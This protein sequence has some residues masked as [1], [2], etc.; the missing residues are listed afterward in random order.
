MYVKFTGA[1]GGHNSPPMQ[2]NCPFCGGFGTFEIVGHNLKT[3]GNT[4]FSIQSCPAIKCKAVVIGVFKGQELQKTYPGLGKPI[5]TE[6][7]PERIKNAFQEGV[8]C[9]ANNCFVAAAIMIRK[10]LEE[11]CIDKGATG[12]NLFKKIQDLSTKI[13]IPKELIEAMHELRLLGNDAAH[14]E[15]ETYNSIGS[16]ELL[17]SIDFTQEIIKAIYQYENLLGKLRSLRIAAEKEQ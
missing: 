3:C 10:T 17:I 9:F 13:L 12:G 1:E 11:I 4:N 5:N 8:D 16:D 15:A 2:I 14:I 6:N 7:V